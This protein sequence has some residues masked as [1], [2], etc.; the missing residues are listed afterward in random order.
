MDGVS[1]LVLIMFSLHGLLNSWGGPT[2][3]R[4]A[5][6]LC[7]LGSLTL[8]V[9]KDLNDHLVQTPTHPLLNKHQV[10]SS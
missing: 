10:N 4:I 3:S 6:L 7:S 8:T 5:A 1:I 9:V 2:N